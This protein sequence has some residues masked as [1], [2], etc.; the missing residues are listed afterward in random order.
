M[1]DIEAPVY[2]YANQMG[3]GWPKMIAKSMGY[4]YPA[5]GLFEAEKTDWSGK[6]IPGNE[7]ATLTSPVAGVLSKVSGAAG[8]AMNPLNKWAAAKALTGGYLPAMA[9]GGAVTAASAGSDLKD[10]FNPMSVLGRGATGALLTGVVKGAGDIYNAVP[11]A[12]QNAGRG[13]IGA[14]LKRAGKYTKY[15]A[16]PVEGLLSENVAQGG[17]TAEIH[18]RAYDRLYELKQA[19]QALFKDPAQAAKTVDASDLTA[20]IDEALAEA[21]KAPNHN[22]ALIKR[23]NIA[24]NDVLRQTTGKYLIHCLLICYGGVLD[25]TLKVL[26][27]RISFL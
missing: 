22:S 8:M 19:K 14:T 21:S 15:N 26:L 6:P 4:K 23:L 12:L 3:L 27:Q 20:P 11:G 25:H 10:T 9:A 5:P 18:S 1:K 7:N 17:D 24:N 13:L 2:S 16:D